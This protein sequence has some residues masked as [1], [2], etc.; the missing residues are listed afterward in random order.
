MLQVAGGGS[1]MDHAGGPL[2]GLHVRDWLP[3][4]SGMRR[5]ER[6]LRRAEGAQLRACDLAELPQGNLA[7]AHWT[8]I[9]AYSALTA[10]SQEEQAQGAQ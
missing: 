10:L 1:H 7:A 6:W 8:A 9:T 3:L 2:G 5:S 4:A